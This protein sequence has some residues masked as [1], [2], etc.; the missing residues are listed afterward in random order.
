MTYQQ[1][2]LGSL[3]VFACLLLSASASFAQASGSATD[4]RNPTPIRDPGVL[5]SLDGWSLSLPIRLSLSGNLVPLAHEFPQCETLEDDVGN[6]VA[7]IPVH[8][9]LEWRPM[10]RLTLSAFSQLGCPIDAGLGALMLYSVP[11]QGSTSLVF[12]TGMYGVPAQF[13]LFGGL[14]SSLRTGLRGAAS[15]IASDARVDLTWQGKDG[16]PYSIGAESV[17]SASKRLTFSS[18]F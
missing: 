15:P 12:A 14:R 5:P 18:G 9:Y 10:P 7:H 2:H 4:E 8:G 16:S 17:G 13:D 6:S 3:S 11:L 1:L